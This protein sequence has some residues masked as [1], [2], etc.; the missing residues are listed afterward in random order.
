LGEA[1]VRSKEKLIIGPGKGMQHMLACKQLPQS[2][3]IFL[4]ADMDVC[5][6][7]HTPRDL[8]I[9]MDGLCEEKASSY[10]LSQMFAG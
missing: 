5:F 7:Y 6:L 10:L 1:L 8:V 9:S 3:D 4:L 2:W